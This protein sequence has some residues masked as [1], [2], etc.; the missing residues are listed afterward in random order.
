MSE[1][2]DLLAD[3][4]SRLPELEWKIKG[5]GASFPVY[6]LPRGLFQTPFGVSGATCIAEIKSDILALS[7]QKNRRSA[8]YL[9][10]RIQQKINV[11]VVL[12]Q[13]HQRKNKA[14]NK[15]SF[16]LKS[17]ST[18]QQWLLALENEINTLTLQHQ[19]LLR[20]MAQ[21]TLEADTASTLNVQKELGQLE[22]Q[23]TL[24]REA[25]QKAIS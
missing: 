11:L 16:S 18:R 8:T 9:A 5:L 2:N 13:Q 10:S 7:L 15:L 21:M 4:S 6:S 17:L 20:T 24:A 22:K 1:F 14:E 23:L 12:C 3:L 19:A 25:L